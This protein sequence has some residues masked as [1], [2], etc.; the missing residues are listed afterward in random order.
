MSIFNTIS[1]S[2][3]T[4]QQRRSLKYNYLVANILTFLMLSHAQAG[5]VVMAVYVVTEANSYKSAHLLNIN[6]AHLQTPHCAEKLHTKRTINLE[7]KTEL[8]Q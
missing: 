5:P 7:L 6:T 1:P 3:P 8:K 4:S 2:S